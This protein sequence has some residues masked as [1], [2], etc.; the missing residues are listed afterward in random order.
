MCIGIIQ[1]SDIHLKEMDKNPILLRKEKI[2]DALSNRLNDVKEVIVLVNG[3]LAY[4]GSKIEYD[5]AFELLYHVQ[6][7]FEKDKKIVHFIFVAG[8]H[9]CD[10]SANQEVRE[11]LLKQIDREYN[12]DVSREI[13][14][15]IKLQKEFEDFIEIFELEKS[16][17]TCNFENGLHKNIVYS[18]GD[19]IINFNLL[20]TAWM[21][22]KH[23][24]AGQMIMPVNML[25][26]LKY[27]VNDINITALHH[28]THWLSPN[29]KRE[30]EQKLFAASDIIL[31]G[32]EH[33][34]NSISILD[35]NGT[36][37]QIEAGALQENG[38]SDKSSFKLFKVVK[39]HMKIYSFDW[40]IQQS[41]YIKNELK[42]FE[43]DSNNNLVIGQ[44]LKTSDIQK[45]DKLI[46]SQQYEEYLDELGAPIMNSDIGQL[47]FD[48]IYVLPDFNDEL[49]KFEKSEKQHVESSDFE[50]RILSLK[51]K[52]WLISGDKES[53]KT[54]LIKY[55]S[56]KY[57][58]KGFFLFVAR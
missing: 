57:L 36:T 20:N 14:K 42:E 27:S 55:L 41:L 16:K 11:L 13:V 53:G 33:M 23:E 8:N 22:E 32:H 58:S 35:K 3:D 10:F 1:F 46:F 47:T 29:N 28:P 50:R 9:D 40:N 25:S 4:S 49:A 45:S 44:Q 51:N 19:I 17:F 39:K 21:S 48:N 24:Q 56:K 34:D 5:L 2:I 15:Q 43:L 37:L 52:I 18:S 6:E 31:T 7:A 54:S 12:F 30:V 38:D 26:E